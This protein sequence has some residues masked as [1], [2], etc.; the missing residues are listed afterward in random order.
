M[1]PTYYEEVLTRLR[2]GGVIVLDNML[3]SGTVLNPQHAA[4]HAIA[5]LNDTI[6]RDARVENVF[7][8]IR[9]GVQVVRKKA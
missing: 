9:D 3:L 7:L 1:Y 5:G 8:T 6:A 2:P 4:A